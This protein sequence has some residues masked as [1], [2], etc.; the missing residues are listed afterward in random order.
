MAGVDLVAFADAARDADLVINASSGGATLDV[1][2]A[3]GADDLAG[4]VLLDL[5]NPL[6]FS[7]GFPPTLLVKD[8]DSLG[9]QVQREFPDT[10][11][12]KSLNTMNN[13]L[14]ARPRTLADGNHTVFV[15]GKYAD[16]KALV[17]GLLSE[18]GHTDVI[19]LGDI[20][21]AR[22]LEMVLPLWVRLMGTLGTAHFQFKIVR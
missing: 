10:R 7:R 9:E 4:R 1:L 3:V 6:D 22:G 16:A 17:T 19:D 15:A 2:R 14:M 12:V 18:L 5:A 13:E 11:V 8:T 21:A 20:T